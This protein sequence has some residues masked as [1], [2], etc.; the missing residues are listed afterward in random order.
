MDD[1]Q[2]A[3]ESKTRTNQLPLFHYKDIY[4][5]LTHNIALRLSDRPTEIDHGGTGDAVSLSNIG[6]AKDT[7][8]FVTLAAK[9]LHNANS[10]ENSLQQQYRQRL[11]KIFEQYVSPHHNTFDCAPA[12]MLCYAYLLNMGDSNIPATVM[13]YRL[14]RDE[15]VCLIDIFQK[16]RDALLPIC[17][18]DQQLPYFG[19]LPSLRLHLTND[20]NQ[21]LEKR[22]NHNRCFYSKDAMYYL[23]LVTPDQRSSYDSS[24]YPLGKIGE[25]RFGAENIQS[26]FKFNIDQD[27]HVSGIWTWLKQQCETPSA[28]LVKILPPATVYEQ[29]STW[30]KC[31]KFC[32]E[33][34]LYVGATLAGIGLFAGF[35]IMEL[36]Q[37]YQN[38]NIFEPGL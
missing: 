33:N 19:G 35:E 23:L 6:G 24:V 13:E 22:L 26:H 38:N 1:R 30:Q 12:L 15:E 3:T 20:F 4:Y 10:D 18:F 17:I 36:Q 37:D 9:L 7:V 21:L 8:E 25:F 27:Y 11:T 28:A 31:V 34:P 5:L 14:P 29:S 32:Q 16:C 2:F